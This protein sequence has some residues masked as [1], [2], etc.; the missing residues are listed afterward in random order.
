VIVIL[1]AA[2]ILFPH[3][4]SAQTIP[5]DMAGVRPGRHRH[6]ERRH[7]HRFV[8]DETSRAGRRPSL[9]PARALIIHHSWRLSSRERRPPVHRGETGKRRG[10]WNA[11][12]DD[13][14]AHPEGTRHVHGTLTPRAAR[15]ATTGDRVELVFDGM[16]MGSFEAPSPTYVLS[17]SRLIQQEAVLTTNDPT[18]RILRRGLRHGGARRPHTRNNMRSQIAYYDTSG[19]LKREAQASRPSAS[20]SKSGTARW[21]RKRRAAASL[22]FPPRINTSFHATSRR[23]SPTSG[24]ADGAGASASASGSSVTR[25]GSTTRG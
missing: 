7:G 1:V 20:R 11:F 25:T 15:A 2:L 18:S 4:V 6:I 3:V 9:D 17:R 19:A 16:R 13:P 21:R 12:F 5:F 14:T 22:C 8:A 24:I 10:G 23:T